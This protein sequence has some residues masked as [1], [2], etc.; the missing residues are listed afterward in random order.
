MSDDK[1]EAALGPADVESLSYRIETAGN[2]I[3]DIGESHGAGRKSVFDGQF[4]NLERRKKMGV[5]IHDYLLFSLNSKSNVI[6]VSFLDI[7]CFT[8]ASSVLSNTLYT[9]ML[10]INLRIFIQ[11]KKFTEKQQSKAKL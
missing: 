1:T 7:H 11:V 3:I 10:N 4:V 2:G 8:V 6:D 9:A 5:L